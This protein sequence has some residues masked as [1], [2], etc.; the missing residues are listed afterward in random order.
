MTAKRPTVSR[1]RQ[2]GFALIE[3]LIAA[4]VLAVGLLGMAALQ[5]VSLKM[6]HGSYVRS[7]ATN[8][9]YEIADAMRANRLNAPSYAAAYAA[10][11]CVPNLSPGSSGVVVTDDIAEWRNR[12]ACLLPLGRGAIALPTNARATITVTWDETRYGGSAT[13]SFSVSTEL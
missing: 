3:A 11:S 13:E 8:L 9:A 10:I 7:Q 5:G 1:P 4:L 12:L 6:N 2:K